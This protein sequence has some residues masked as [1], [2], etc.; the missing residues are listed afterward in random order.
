MA[1]KSGKYGSV[2]WGASNYAYANKWDLDVKA[3]AEQFGVFGGHGW[4]KGN[5]GQKA[6]TGTISGVYDAVNPL[7]DQ[8][9]IGDS[10]TLTLG[11]YV[12]KTLSGTA[13]IT[14]IKITVDGDTGAKTT[15]SLSF[16]TDGVWDDFDAVN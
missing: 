5:V 8:I 3:D 13:Q 12:G 14:D 6:G 16:Q 15:W 11:I 2:S 7:D 9:H 1:S 4:K 10:V